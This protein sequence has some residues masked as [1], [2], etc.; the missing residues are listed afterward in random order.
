M[1]TQGKQRTTVQMG[2]AASQARLLSLTARL[3]DVEFEAQAIEAAKLKLADAEDEVYQRYLAALDATQITGQ[4]MKGTQTATVF[5]N[6]NNLCGGWEN[7][8]LTNEGILGYGLVNQK[9]GKLYVNAEMYQAYKNYN[10]DDSDEFALKQLGYSSA[11]IEAYLK[12]RDTKGTYY[13][14]DNANQ[15]SATIGLR[16]V[17]PSTDKYNS[18]NKYYEKDPMS[19]GYKEVPSMS[20]SI[21][22]QTANGEQ[23]FTSNARQLY[24]AIQEGENRT[25]SLNIVDV[26]AMKNELISSEGQYYKNTFEMIIARNGCEVLEKE[27]QNSSEWLTNMVGYGNVGIYTLEKDATAD[28]GYKMQRTSTS[29]SSILS[30]TNVT[31]LDNTELKRAEA[32]YNKDLKAINKKD[33]Q[34]DLALED[35]ET[36]RT[37]ITTEMESV[38]KVIDENVERTFGVFS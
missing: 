24:T 9:S 1:S 5:A 6:F 8:I 36:E 14:I 37:A 18:T 20:N 28:R 17:N 38:R 27:N 32:E 33:T 31:S 34:F 15:G 19:G 3:H 11:E 13:P 23:K 2:M 22:L 4:V 16:A 12:H 29:T 35:L 25:P 26:Y 10:G 21:Y 7:M 30:D